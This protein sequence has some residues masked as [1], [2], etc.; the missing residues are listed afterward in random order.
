[1][2]AA[3]SGICN[4]V[5]CHDRCCKRDSLLEKRKDSLDSVVFGN[6]SPEPF[7]RF[8]TGNVEAQLLS[9]PSNPPLQKAAYLPSAGDGRLPC[10][11]S[12]RTRPRS[13]RFKRRTS[14]VNRSSSGRMSSASGGLDQRRSSFTYADMH[15]PYPSRSESVGRNLSPPFPSV[16][17]LERNI[18]LSDRRQHDRRCSGKRL[19]SKDVGCA[20]SRSVTSCG[21]MASSRKSTVHG[22]ASHYCEK[23]SAKSNLEGTSDF[24]YQLGK[25][26]KL[27]VEHFRISVLVGW[28]L[29][30]LSYYNI[31]LCSKKTALFLQ[32]DVKGSL[33]VKVL[34]PSIHFV[35]ASV[36]QLIE[37]K[38]VFTAEDVAEKASQRLPLKR[39]TRATE[40]AACAYALHQGLRRYAT[41]VAGHQ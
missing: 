35:V 26:T 4:C 31:C 1:M 40:V 15:G 14:S 37:I 32:V 34:G 33:A 10:D 9:R 20:K 22:D 2:G 36:K 19:L 21:R 27:L 16:D 29:C 5:G 6:N 17:E 13:S 23:G 25:C 18:A 41:S 24:P 39:S 12:Y 7:R 8:L 11:E 30:L 38:R 3:C 28:K